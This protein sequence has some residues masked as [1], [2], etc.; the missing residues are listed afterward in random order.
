MLLDC[1]K[2]KELFDVGGEDFIEFE[3]IWLSQGSSGCDGKFNSFYG[4]KHT[5][6]TKQVLREKTLKLLEDPEFR[7][8][9][10]QAGEKNGMYGSKRFGE[11]NP[12]F[13]KKQSDQTKKKISDKAK[14]RYSKGFVN[15][16]KGKKLSEETKKKI[17]EK[18]SKLYVIR[19]PNGNII[20]I[21]NLTKYCLENNLNY[22]MMIRVSKGLVKKHKGYTTP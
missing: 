17:S 12:M 2:L 21:K 9:R 1:R 19:H 6:E 15:C 8:T 18:N 4:L 20:Q 7:K 10:S 22:I 16:N 11:L 5:E 14:E 13:G 3:E